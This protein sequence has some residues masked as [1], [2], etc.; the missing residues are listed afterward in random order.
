MNYSDEKYKHLKFKLKCKQLLFT[1]KIF[2]ITK[3]RL[4]C[5]TTM[6]WQQKTTIL[7]YKQGLW[8]ILIFYSVEPP[9]LMTKGCMKSLRSMCE[10]HRILLSQ[11][12]FSV[13][14]KKAST[15]FSRMRQKYGLFVPERARCFESNQ[16]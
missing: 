13:S 9:L 11:P 3:T 10:H 6:A 1:I 5:I 4:N 2:C 7:F 12:I 16:L 8:H 15:W 14:L